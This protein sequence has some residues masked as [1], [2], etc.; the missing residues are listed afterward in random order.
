[1][2]QKTTIGLLFFIIIIC[3]Q[4]YSQDRSTILTS[5]PFK[6][7]RLHKIVEYS[8]YLPASYYSANLKYPVIYLLHGFGGD[9]TSWLERCNLAKM[10]D[11]LI[12]V[13]IFPETI[14]VMP[15]GGN[16][17]FINNY[18]SSYNFEDFFI[19]EFIPS[20]ESEY[21]IIQQQRAR[22]ICG[23]SMGGFGSIIL[24]VKHPG[25]FGYSVALSATVRTP[26]EFVSLSQFKY[27]TNFSKIF[28]DTLKGNNRITEHWKKNSPYFLI[29]NIWVKQK[30]WGVNNLLFTL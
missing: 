5:V 11:S 1:M 13:G 18:D 17:Y 8:V 15:D 27:Q 24:P 26:G 20:I 3:N 19:D 23:L 2:F 25:L 4:Q 10:A 12:S 21:R 30:S 29:D 6:S 9:E 7:D 28:G 16:S 14:I 22:A